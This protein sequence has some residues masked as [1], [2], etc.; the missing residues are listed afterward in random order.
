MGTT[1]G[2]LARLALAGSVL[3]LAAVAAPPAARALF[4]T[5]CRPHNW[6]DWHV[7]MRRECLSP[8]YVCRNMTTAK[9]LDD[10]AVAAGYREALQAGHDAWPALA[11]V[12]GQMRQRYG[13]EPERDAGDPAT[14]APASR[15]PPG[16]PA[17]DFEPAPS[18]TL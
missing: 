10:P 15:L 18:T 4:A 14:R 8:A 6:V 3:S 2:R 1:L 12:V 13:C 9:M 16:H 11:D 17:I 5:G 7:A